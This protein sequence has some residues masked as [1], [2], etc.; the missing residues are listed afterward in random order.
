MEG[1]FNKKALE[2]PILREISCTPITD[3][4][5][6]K[7]LITKEIINKATKENPDLMELIEGPEAWSQRAYRLGVDEH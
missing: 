3:I 4:D 2:A 5:E 7:W 1:K 6:I